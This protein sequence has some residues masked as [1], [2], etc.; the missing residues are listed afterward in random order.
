MANSK[1]KARQAKREEMIE[2]IL[3]LALDL[4]LQRLENVDA[5]E[6]KDNM[7]FDRVARTAQVLIR[8]ADDA[9]SLAARKRKEQ[10]DHDQSGA[11]ADDDARVEREAAVLKGRLDKYID[12]LAN[13]AAQS[14]RRPDGARDGDGAGDRA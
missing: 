6:K 10:T 3:D 8:V 13:S 7:I 4:T 11:N 12:G 5:K 9:D 2:S 1:A 14:D